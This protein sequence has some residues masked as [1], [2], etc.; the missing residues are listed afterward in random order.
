MVKVIFH[1][2]DVM[3]NSGLT[4]GS[5]PPTLGLENAGCFLPMLHTTAQTFP[6]ASEER[7][8]G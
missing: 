8:W 4:P 1:N 6:A 7:N 3:G 2:S 5:R